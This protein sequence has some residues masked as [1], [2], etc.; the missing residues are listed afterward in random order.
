MGNAIFTNQAD[1][2]CHNPRLR[3]CLLKTNGQGRIFISMTGEPLI[4]KVMAWD[5]S[6]CIEYTHVINPFLL[7]ALDH[8]G[9]Q[10]GQISGPIILNKMLTS[11]PLLRCK[12]H[13]LQ[14]SCGSV[15]FLPSGANSV[16]GKS[17]DSAFGK[18][19]TGV[20]LF[21]WDFTH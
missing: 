19:W 11:F 20:S 15:E 8:H 12:F 4:N 3:D 10:P 1:H 18:L 16:L 14:N 6:H 7:Q 21:H 9:A 17:I 5:L 2:T 13:W